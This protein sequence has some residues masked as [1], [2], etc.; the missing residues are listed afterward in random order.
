MCPSGRAAKGSVLIGVRQ[1][2]GKIA[3]LPQSLP[4]TDELLQTTI[5]NGHVPE[6]LFR[7]SHK[8]AKAGC[9]RWNDGGCSVATLM[10]ESINEFSGQPLPQ[11][12]IRP[13]CR[14]YKQAGE[15]V[16]RVCPSVISHITEE[17]IQRFN[18]LI[19]ED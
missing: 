11:C 6:Q 13:D 2:D 16:C 19:K 10:Q 5:S 15:G 12:S 9:A 3:M 4:V 1:A 18:H 17:E 7:F 8:C 14:W